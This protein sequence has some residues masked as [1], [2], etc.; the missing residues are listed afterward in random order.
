MAEKMAFFWIA[1]PLNCIAAVLAVIISAGAVHG[2]AIDQDLFSKRYP[3]LLAFDL[4]D[5]ERLHAALIVTATASL[6]A[7]DINVSLPFRILRDD[8]TNEKGLFRLGRYNSW[9]LV[10][11]PP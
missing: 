3:I 6:P 8:G 11:F 10:T 4:Q 7:G 2:A 5:E 1:T 9:T